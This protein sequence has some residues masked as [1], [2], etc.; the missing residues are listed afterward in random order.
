MLYIAI[1]D[2]QNDVWGARMP[3]L[4]GVHGGGAT[5]EEAIRNV[6]SAAHEWIAHVL[7]RGHEIPKAR[8]LVDLHNAG[9]VSVSDVIFVVELPVKPDQ[10]RTVNANV[11]FDAGLLEAIDEAAAEL[12]IT[13]SAFLACAARAKIDADT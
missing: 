5:M 7:L 11:T 1:L 6:K 8:N 4:P 2:G 13:R 3:D 9:E 10:V 12:G